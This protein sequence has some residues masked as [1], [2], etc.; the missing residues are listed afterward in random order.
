MT[1]LLNDAT[2]YEPTLAKFNP[3]C[4]R[5]TEFYFESRYP[6]FPISVAVEKEV[7]QMLT[8]AEELIA[9]SLAIT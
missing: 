8:E 7:R 4:I 6:L 5:V 1:K 9:K 2:V 3:L